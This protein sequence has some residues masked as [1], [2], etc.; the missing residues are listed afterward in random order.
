MKGAK[1]AQ[2]VAS[3]RNDEAGAAPPL[4]LHWPALLPR[5]A[6]RDQQRANPGGIGRGVMLAA[7]AVIAEFKKQPKP[8]TTPEEIAQVTMISAKG[9]QEIGNII[10]DAMKKVGRKV[11]SQ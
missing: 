5:R 9:D 1:L 8:V 11:S 10:A 7:D 6:L 3:N 4:L 2:D